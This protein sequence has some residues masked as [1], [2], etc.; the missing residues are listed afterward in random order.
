VTDLQPL[1]ESGE[2]DF[3]RALL[4]SVR[5]ELP[6]PAGLHDTALAL[7]LAASTAKALAGALP[8]TGALGAALGVHGLSVGGTGGALASGASGGTGGAL[9]SGASGG[10]ALASGATSTVGALGVASL[11]ALGKS[12]VGGA[13][14]SFVALTAIDQTRAPSSTAP[15]RAVHS[16]NV[17]VPIV[18][19]SEEPGA[20]PVQAV[21]VSAATETEPAA[22]QAPAP[23]GNRRA[24]SP[25]SEAARVVVA[26]PAPAAPA[27]SAFPVDPK[28]AAVTA[29][30]NAS[31]A[32]EIRA[33]DQARSALA[34]GDT[35]RASQ[36]LDEYAANRPS[37]TL[38]QEA[39]LLRVRVLLNR[40]QR[41]AAATLA[42]RIIAQH[43]ESAHVESL[44]RLAA[45]P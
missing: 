12:L 25:A 16:L 14:V 18:Q 27:R 45:E 39:A 41:S 40:G 33:L 8:T 11:G 37:S 5:A 6:G 38:S 3:E 7:G 31:L 28:Q 29:A 9:A 4:Q 42:R 19:R 10:A 35:N 34:A 36:L 24:P 21:P 1:L 23:V 2:D 15:S 43:P 32:A 30:A 26:P 44:R 20:T 17:A 22:P 13:L